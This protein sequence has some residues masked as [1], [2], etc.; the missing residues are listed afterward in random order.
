MCG[1]TPPPAMV[2]LI[3]QK[4]GKSVRRDAQTKA[5]RHAQRVQLLVAADGELQVARRDALHLKKKKA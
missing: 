2:A 3:L 5:P 4:E 1:M